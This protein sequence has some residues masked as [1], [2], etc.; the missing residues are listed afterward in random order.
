MSAIKQ[1]IDKDEYY[2]AV[3]SSD[4]ILEY[5]N[6]IIV[7]HAA[8]SAFHQRIVTE[9]SRQIGNYIASHKGGCGVFVAP[10]EVCIN[11]ND[12]VQPDISVVCDKNKITTRGCKGT[13]D[14]VVEVLSSNRAYDTIT[15]GMLYEKAGVKEYCII[16]PEA[17]LITIRRHM[18]KGS[19]EYTTKYGFSDNIIITAFG[20]PLDYFVLNLSALETEEYPWNK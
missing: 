1:L 10:F 7:A 4:E 9:V 17:K 8:P 3:E 5:V 6:G 16:D 14:F 18:L 11:D 12:V 13:P 19:E 15:K 20:S 2:T